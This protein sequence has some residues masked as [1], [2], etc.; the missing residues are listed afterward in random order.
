MKTKFF[1][2]F[3]MVRVNLFEYG[4][5]RNPKYDFLVCG[6]GLSEYFEFPEL[7]DKLVLKL[8][9]YPMK[10]SY[11]INVKSWFD[12]GNILLTNGESKI[13]RLSISSLYFLRNMKLTNTSLYVALDYYE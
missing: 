13:L 5:Y 8:S 9:N 11:L 1:E 10:D 2:K 6:N 12:G 7:T 3:E 4:H